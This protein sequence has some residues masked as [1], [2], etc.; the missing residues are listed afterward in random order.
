LIDLYRVITIELERV[1]SEH[2][3]GALRKQEL[4]QAKPLAS[5]LDSP[6]GFAGALGRALNKRVY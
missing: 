5:Y 2:L 4:F 1:V 6:L 3:P